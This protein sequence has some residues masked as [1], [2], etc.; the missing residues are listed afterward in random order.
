MPLR[1]L[2][3]YG[4]LGWPFETSWGRDWRRQYYKKRRVSGC[5]TPN[6]LRTLRWRRVFL[7]LVASLRRISTM[8]TYSLVIAFRVRV[9]FRNA[10][11][12]DW[13]FDKPVVVAS[14]ESWRDFVILRELL[15]DPL[16]DLAGQMM[17]TTVSTPG[18][19]PFANAR[20]SRIFGLRRRLLE[21]G[22]VW[23][24]APKLREKSFIQ[25]SSKYMQCVGEMKMHCVQSF[26]QVS[27]KRTSYW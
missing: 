10:V 22:R 9:V 8:L 25:S 2:L 14:S 15:H 20:V 6:S 21:C 19:R 27:C 24:G 3:R 11:V 16:C 4:N 5:I 7:Q 12:S 26:S 17:M 18:F 13:R 23:R 1:L